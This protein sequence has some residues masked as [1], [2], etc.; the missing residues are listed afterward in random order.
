MNRLGLKI[1]CLLVA[2]LI[3][4]QVAG[5]SD[6]EQTVSLPIEVTGLADGL[7]TLGSENLPARVRV[8]LTGS[9]RDLLAHQFFNKDIGQVTV[10]LAGL[11]DTTLSYRLSRADIRTKMVNPEIVGV[12]NITI[13]TDHQVSRMIPV[14]L[15]TEGDLPAGLDFVTRPVP[16]PDSVEVA[17]PSRFFNDELTIQTETLELDRVSENSSVA[18]DLLSLGEFLKPARGE[19]QVA[20]R[21]GRLERRVLANIPVVALVDAGRPEVGVSPPVADVTVEGFADSLRILT[22]DRISVVVSADTLDV[23][24]HRRKGQVVA[25]DWVTFSEMNPSEFQVIVGNPAELE[26]WAPGGSNREDRGE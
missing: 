18:A 22:R 9:K 14:S 20:F 24:L 11:S 8:R 15:V 16:E 3:W 2:M 23:G 26:R 21:V 12:R 6:L 10:N 7:T 5:N 17:G 1:S 25:P 19:V 13:T 4:F